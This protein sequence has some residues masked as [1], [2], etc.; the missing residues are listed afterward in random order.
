MLR[1]HTSRSAYGVKKYFET[2]DYYSEGQETVGLWGGKLAPELGLSGMVTKEAFDRLCDNINPATG[3]PLTP[4]TRENRRVGD[5]MVFSLMKDVGAFIMLLPPEERDALLAMVESR[6]EQVMGVIEGDMQCRIRKDD[7]DADRTTGNF[8]YASFLHT[9]ARPVAGRPPDPHPHW[10]MFTF[11]ATRDAEEG[12]IKA[13]QMASIFRDRPFYE[14]LFFALV[15]GDFRRAGLPIERRANG[16]WGMAGLESLISTFS[17]RTGEI[18]EE[19]RRLDITDEGRKS[20]LGA[21]TRSKKDKVM[22]PEELHEDWH[23]QLTDE[24]RDA[25]GRARRKEFAQA[26]AV[27]A[28]EAVAFAVEHCFYQYSV[29]PERELQRVALQ[30]GMGSVTLDQINAELP[31]HGVFVQEI[32]GRRMA[33]TEALQ[34]EEDDIAGL[35]RA[36]GAR[37]PRSASSAAS[38]GRRPMARS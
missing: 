6:V 7:M 3:E 29:V 20:R 25:F 24:Q 11:N 34:A 1:L 31:R 4:R 37:W 8:A 10:H 2:A 15:A 21:T 30:H 22:T 32:D 28:R 33:T 27:T 5:D 26:R 18:E 13:A 23:S 35:R 9:T 38:P 14:D 17:K 36:G 16:K 19:A 12:C